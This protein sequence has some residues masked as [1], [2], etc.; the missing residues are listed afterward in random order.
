MACLRAVPV[1]H[2]FSARPTMFILH[3]YS[4]RRRAQDCHVWLE[5]LAPTI[6]PEYDTVRVS[7]DTAI[8]GWL[9]DIT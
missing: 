2:G 4:G 8:H 9:G 3:M 1:V 5:Q 6:L 7:M